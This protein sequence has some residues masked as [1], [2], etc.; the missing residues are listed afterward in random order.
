MKQ[1]LVI[2]V[3]LACLALPTAA[4]A[5]PKPPAAP[6]SAACKAQL[7]AIGSAEFKSL[8]GNM[9]QCVAKMK[10]ASGAEK[11][12]TLNAA[13][14]CKAERGTTEA[15]RE[16]FRQKYGSNP[17]KANAFGKCVSA[18]AKSTGEDNEQE[19]KRAR[20]DFT[21]TADSV[22]NRHVIFD[23][24]AKNKN[25]GGSFS[26]AD[27]TSSYSVRVDCVLITGATVLI[28]GLVQNPVGFAPALTSPTYLLAKAVDNGASG[29]QY[30]GQ[31]VSTNP[32]GASFG[33]V[34]PAGGLYPVTSGG[35]TVSR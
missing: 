13:K 6:G 14:Q 15:S 11:S 27:A 26:Y 35:I 1:K 3:A 7:A 22:S 24:H 10:R 28:G 5:K 34:L 9:G 25:A 29:D 23:L 4:L 33:T 2:T 31:F 20:A 32:C 12:S 21:F 8:Y 18:K 30:N 16:A 19:A 17:N